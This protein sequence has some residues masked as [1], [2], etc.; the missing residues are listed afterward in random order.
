MSRLRK[1]GHGDI[2]GFGQPRLRGLVHMR[3]EPRHAM[4]Q[5]MEILRIEHQ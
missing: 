3:G 4:K 1:F 2:A 5:S